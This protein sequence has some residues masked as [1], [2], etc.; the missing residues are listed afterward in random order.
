VVWRFDGSVGFIDS[1]Y[2]SLGASSQV[3]DI[4]D[5]V[6]HTYYDMKYFERKS[7]LRAENTLPVVPLTDGRDSL[8]HRDIRT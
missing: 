6:V 1:G 7:R 5:Q 3:A 8:G 2:I 4:H